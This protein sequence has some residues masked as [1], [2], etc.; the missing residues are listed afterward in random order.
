MV[1]AESAL[2]TGLQERITLPVEFIQVIGR[3]HIS[4]HDDKQDHKNRG[5]QASR[6]GDSGQDQTF[7]KHGV[8]SSLRSMRQKASATSIVYLAHFE[9]RSA[10]KTDEEE[11][12]E[13]D[14]WAFG[15]KRRWH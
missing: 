14:M 15:H 1:K 5:Q 9:T 3:K 11:V 4:M 8:R 7:P 6:A 10:V 13:L 2:L 12:L